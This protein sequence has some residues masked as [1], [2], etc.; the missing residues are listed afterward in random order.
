VIREAGGLIIAD[1][2]QPGFGR[3][4]THFWGHDWLGFAPDVVTMGKPM[5]NG[6]PVAAV[7]ARPDVMAAFRR[8]SAISTPSAAIRCRPR[9]AWRCWT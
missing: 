5:A 6:H 8:R 1:E 7:L 2:V 9:P 4:G 3:L